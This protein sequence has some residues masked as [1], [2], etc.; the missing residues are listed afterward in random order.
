MNVGSSF[1]VESCFE[2]KMDSLVCFVYQTK[3]AQT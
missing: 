3:F 2:L 1:E